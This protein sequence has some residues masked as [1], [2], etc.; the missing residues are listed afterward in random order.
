MRL[1][2]KATVENRLIKWIHTLQQHI[3]R[4]VKSTSQGALQTK[5]FS[6]NT[7][8]ISALFNAIEQALREV[9]GSGRATT[10]GQADMWSI[11]QTA[12]I[13]DLFVQSILSNKGLLFLIANTV[14]KIEDK[15]FNDIRL[16]EIEEVPTTVLG[17]EPSLKCSLPRSAMQSKIS[18]DSESHDEPIVAATAPV[19]DPVATAPKMWNQKDGTRYVIPHLT[20]FWSEKAA[21]VVIRLM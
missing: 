6:L 8:L 10:M 11:V 4:T 14:G 2:V 20:G 3:F 19:A 15:A 7:S 1:Y 12:T 18:S 17:D 16:R 5:Y 21:S 9:I 13:A